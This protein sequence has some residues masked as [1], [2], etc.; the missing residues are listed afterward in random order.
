M[1][2]QLVAML[3]GSRHSIDVRK[4]QTG[5]DALGIQVQGQSHQIYIA[6]ALAIAKKTAFYAVCACH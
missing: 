1:D 5:I 6:G 2:G 4:I 3:D